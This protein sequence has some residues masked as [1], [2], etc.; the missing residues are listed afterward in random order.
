[1]L[2]ERLYKFYKEF[3]FF[4]RKGTT[5]LQK[6]S[7]LPD[8]CFG[9]LGR[10]GNVFLFVFFFFPP[11]RFTASWAASLAVLVRCLAI[12]VFTRPVRVVFS[13]LVRLWWFVSSRIS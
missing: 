7:V 9:L 13:A 1:M 2:L 12:V 4:C 5:L 11:V 6:K 8:V 3:F 10:G